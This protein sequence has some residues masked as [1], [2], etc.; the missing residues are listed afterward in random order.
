MRTKVLIYLAMLLAGQVLLLL[1]SQTKRHTLKS[2]AMAMEPLIMRPDG[3]AEG[4][5]DEALHGINH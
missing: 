2:A 3:A 4:F 1:A 5:K